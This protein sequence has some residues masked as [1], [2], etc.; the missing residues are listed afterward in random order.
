M[1]SES[2]YLKLPIKHRN[3]QLGQRLFELQLVK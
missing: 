3:R 2:N 1:V